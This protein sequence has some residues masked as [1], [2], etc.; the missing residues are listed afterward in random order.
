M[1]ITYAQLKALLDI[2]EP[3]YAALAEKAEGA[4]HHVRKMAESDDPSLASKA[5][6][7]A[8]FIGDDD[9]TAVVG[10]AA[11]SRHAVVRVAAAHAATL[12]PDSTKAARVIEKLIDDKDLGVAKF[13]ARAASRQSDATLARKVAPAKK[14]VAT[15]ARAAAQQADRDERSAT[16]AAKK[17][18]K[19]AAK[20]SAA[21][22]RAPGKRAGTASADGMPRGDMVNPPGGAKP[23]AMPTG[24]MK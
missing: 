12:L 16:M 23:G 22:K 13:A 20:T 10:A 2:D 8:G 1:P 9:G 19:K 17:A 5:V 11:R 14:R 4:M 15:L 21:K 18:A 7:L 24:S 3:D 6:S